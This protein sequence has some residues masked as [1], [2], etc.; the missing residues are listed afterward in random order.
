M[1]FSKPEFLE[2][3]EC[4]DEWDFFTELLRKSNIADTKK[5]SLHLLITLGF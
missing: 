1:L 3:G 5:V 4:T 2:Q